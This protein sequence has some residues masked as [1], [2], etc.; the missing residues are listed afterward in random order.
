MKNIKKILLGVLLLVGVI[1][2]VMYLSTKPVET[3]TEISKV[4]TT[5]EVFEVENG[6]GYIIK[7]NNKVLIKQSIIP[8]VQGNIPFKTEEEALL[9]GKLVENKLKTKKNPFVTIEELSELNIDIS[10]E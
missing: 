5:T 9:I 7:A 10:K 1:F 3:Q 2:L 6:Y 4:P 8:A